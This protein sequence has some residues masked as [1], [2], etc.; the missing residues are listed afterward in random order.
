LAALH[1]RHSFESGRRP[2][3]QLLVI[4]GQPAALSDHR[5]DALPQSGHLA[6]GLRGARLRRVGIGAGLGHG[7]YERRETFASPSPLAL[8]REEALLDLR[9]AHGSRAPLLLRLAALGREDSRLADQARRLLFRHGQV[10]ADGHEL[11]LGGVDA[12]FEGARFGRRGLGQGRF[13]GL[14]RTGGRQEHGD[15]GEPRRDLADL[16]PRSQQALDAAPSFH[17]A[18]T[19]RLARE[20]G[21]GNGGVA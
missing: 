15:L 21:A 4:L 13:L 5:R 6:L 10:V 11:F 17:H 14:A 18:S 16:A 9:E 7:G 8:G 2:G 19:D 12:L 3:Q 1:L 20:R